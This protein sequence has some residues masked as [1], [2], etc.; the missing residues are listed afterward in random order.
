MSAKVHRV[1]SVAQS[2]VIDIRIIKYQDI[3]NNEVV[4]LKLV[5]EETPHFNEM[6]KSTF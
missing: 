1:K 4:Q 5:E 2:T 6:K 3:E